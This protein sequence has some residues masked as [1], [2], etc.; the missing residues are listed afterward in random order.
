[1]SVLGVPQ[2]VVVGLGQ[3]APELDAGV[4]GTAVAEFGD[5]GV[6]EQIA[7]HAG[8]L[9]SLARKE[10]CNRRHGL[11]VDDGLG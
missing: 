8:L 6:L 9:G 10:E 7:A 11:S 4:L 5:L 1:L 3:Q 2:L